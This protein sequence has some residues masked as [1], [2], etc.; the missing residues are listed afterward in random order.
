MKGFLASSTDWSRAFQ[1]EDP[2]DVCTNVTNNIT[3]AMDIYI[4]G[5]LVS[6]KPET[7]YGLMTT[8]RVQQLKSVACSGNSRK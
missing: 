8:A 6:K 2:E 1:P 5:K 3:D 4:P 7:R